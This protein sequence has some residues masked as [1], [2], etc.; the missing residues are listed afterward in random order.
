MT[1]VLTHTTVHLLQMGK[2]TNHT[3]STLPLL[4]CKQTQ[5][6]ISTQWDHNF[7]SLLQSPSP[8]HQWN[9]IS[10]SQTLNGNIQ[11]NMT[12]PTSL[13]PTELF[14]QKMLIQHSKTCTSKTETPSPQGMMMFLATL[15]PVKL[16]D[17]DVSLS[18]RNL[19]KPSLKLTKLCSTGVNSLTLDLSMH[20]TWQKPSS[21][22]LFQGALESSCPHKL[23]SPRCQREH[24]GIHL[25]NV[26]K[27]YKDWREDGKM[28]SPQ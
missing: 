23:V 26:W 15:T 19:L 27:Q 6:D 8:C 7:W 4:T 22:P 12:C 16:Q 14:G 18:T 25:L 20:K 17:I 24:Q 2:I 28:Y 11:K 1:M 10:P 3:R 5:N 9:L 13:L 21:K